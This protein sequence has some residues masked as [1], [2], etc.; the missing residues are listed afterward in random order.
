MCINNEFVCKMFY[1]CLP[2]TAVTETGEH[3]TFFTHVTL[4]L[5]PCN[6]FIIFMFCKCSFKICF[7]AWL[8][9]TA[10]TFLLNRDASNLKAE[11]I[12]SAKRFRERKNRGTPHQTRFC[13]QKHPSLP[14]AISS[15]SYL[16]SGG[17]CRFCL[18]QSFDCNDWDDDLESI[19]AKLHS[20]SIV[21][22]HM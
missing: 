5:I 8:Q 22:L 14:P 1:P 16:S 15:E 18:L 17:V 10:A 3:C 19:S 11:S 20:I 9:Q 13:S 4:Q 7:R 21:V 12:I 2:L 6:I